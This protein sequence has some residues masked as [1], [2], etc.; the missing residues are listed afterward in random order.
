MGRYIGLAV[1]RHAT[2]RQVFSRAIRPGSDSTSRCFMI[3][4]SDIAKGC[5]SSL[6]ETLSRSPSRATNARRVGSASAAKVRSS[7]SSRYLT[8]WFTIGGA[9]WKSSALMQICPWL[10]HNPDRA[11]LDAKKPRRSTLE[12]TRPEKCSER[13][14]HLLDIG[15][16]DHLLPLLRFSGDIGA[17]LLRSLDQRLAAEFDQTLL[18][19][20]FGQD[21]VDLGVELGD[22][23][24]RRVLRRPHTEQRARL[25]AGHGGG[26]RRHIGQ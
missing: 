5:A 7:T 23:F 25:I 17:E 1:K 24:L 22:D 2:V 4:G 8:I 11:S 3:A 26:D 18:H 14:L 13:L 16:V 21:R 10:N 9:I 6:T 12:A 15:A 20:R 19:V